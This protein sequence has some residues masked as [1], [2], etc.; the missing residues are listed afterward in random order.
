MKP[1]KALIAIKISEL[2]KP[3]AIIEGILSIRRVAT[4]IH[5][6]SRALAVSN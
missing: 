3:R 5:Y 2:E 4:R 6:E 1:A